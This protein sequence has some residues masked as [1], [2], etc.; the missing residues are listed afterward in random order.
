MILSLSA[1]KAAFPTDGR[2]RP[3]FVGLR[4]RPLDG[5][6]IK[7]RVRMALRLP[8][9]LGVWPASRGQG[10][11]C[12]EARGARGEGREDGPQAGR[13]STRASPVAGPG[14]KDQVNLTDADS[15]RRRLGLQR[16]SPGGGRQPRGPKEAPGQATNRAGA[17]VAGCVVGVRRMPV[18]P[19]GLAHG[20]RRP[21][22]GTGVR[23][24]PTSASSR[25]AAWTRRAVRVNASH[26]KG[27]RSRSPGS[28]LLLPPTSPHSAWGRLA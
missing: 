27:K 8:E 7:V 3:K 5:W 9:E 4:P 6:S 13:P 24:H 28:C 10:G 21:A 15:R 23:H 22:A 26:R 14:P 20:R 25:Y 18:G 19:A 17:V 1:S 11:D 12:G 2:C 16:P